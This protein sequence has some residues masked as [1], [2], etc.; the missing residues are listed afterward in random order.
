MSDGLTYRKPYAAKKLEF[1]QETVTRTDFFA[2]HFLPCFQRMY[3]KYLKIRVLHGSD[4]C[5]M[6]F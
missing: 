6:K 4:M 5:V 3:T 1:S 2:K